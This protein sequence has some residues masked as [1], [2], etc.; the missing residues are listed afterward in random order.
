MA[1][2]LLLN[3]SYEPLAVITQRRAVSLLL[4]GRV[5]AACT[6]E[7]EIQGASLWAKLPEGR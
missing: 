2:V 5:E 3:A 4:K 6:E 1:E 7:V